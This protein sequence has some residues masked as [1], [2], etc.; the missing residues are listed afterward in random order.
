MTRLVRY[1]AGRLVGVARRSELGLA[2]RSYAEIVEFWQTVE[3]LSPQSVGKRDA[4]KWLSV[5]R[6]GEPL[7][8]EAGHK[9]TKQRFSD[10]RVWRHTVYRGIYGLESVFEMLKRVFEPDTESY[11]LRPQGKS[12]IAAFWSTRTGARCSAPRCCRAAPG[13]L[14]RCCATRRTCAT[15]W[16]CFRM[17]PWISVRRGARSWPMRHSTP[18]TGH[19]CNPP[20]SC[21]TSCTSPRPWPSTPSSASASGA[22]LRNQVTALAV[23]VG[24]LY[25]GRNRRPRHPR[26]QHDLPLPTRRRD[27]LPFRLRLPHQCHG[28]TNRQRQR[29][30]AAHTRRRARPPRLRTHRRSTRRRLPR[31]RDVT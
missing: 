19:P 13:D 11:D 22:L 12:A 30:T 3:M 21:S 4:T 7:P 17:P 28:P 29:A 20:V 8:W 1:A 10:K 15:G 23:V 5:V 2:D 18:V 14:A 31:R 27:R 24:Y 6:A 9:L 26:S 16:P 25:F